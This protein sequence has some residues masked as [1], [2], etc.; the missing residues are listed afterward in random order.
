MTHPAVNEAA[1]IG[2]PDPVWGEE[3]A[4]YVVAAEGAQVS[5]ADILAH[6]GQTLPDFKRPRYVEFVQAL[7]KSDRGKVRRADLR[8]LWSATLPGYD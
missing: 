2:V 4:C 7:P 6:A 8:S 5:V 1:V 3:I